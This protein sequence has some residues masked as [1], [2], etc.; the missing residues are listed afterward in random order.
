MFNA[1]DKTKPERKIFMKN[2][3][4]RSL[5]LMMVIVI[6]ST[7]CISTFAAN[8]TFSYST[9]NTVITKTVQFNKGLGTNKITVVNNGTS[10]IDVYIGGIYRGQLRQGQQLTTAHYGNAFSKTTYSVKI[11]VRDKTYGKQTYRIMTTSR[12]SIR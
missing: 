6:I 5:S 1:N 11:H 4:K 12:G 7:L 2:V 9:P 3:L 10:R 8:K